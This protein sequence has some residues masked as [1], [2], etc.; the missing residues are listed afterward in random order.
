MPSRPRGLLIS[1]GVLASAS[2]GWHFDAF[3]LPFPAA[4]S[5]E[6]VKVLVSGFAAWSAAAAISPSHVDGSFVSFD[7]AR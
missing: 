6:L 4:G 3:G 7:V 2:L 1:R 5:A